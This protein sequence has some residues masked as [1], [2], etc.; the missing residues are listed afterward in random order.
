MAGGSWWPVAAGG[1]L[2]DP[3]LGHHGAAQPELQLRSPALLAP[4]R[5]PWWPLVTRHAGSHIYMENVRQVRSVAILHLLEML[6]GRKLYVGTKPGSYHHG[7]FMLHF[8]IRFLHIFSSPVRHFI[9]PQ[10]RRWVSCQLPDADTRPGNRF[11]APM[12]V[13][14]INVNT[15]QW[16]NGDWDD[17]GHD[18]MPSD[19]RTFFLGSPGRGN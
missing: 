7:Y 6:R 12:F 10:S 15:E 5:D 17:L 13:Y 19:K 14:I 1:R 2:L 4:G 11:H 9:F 8:D 3:S 16:G 18:G